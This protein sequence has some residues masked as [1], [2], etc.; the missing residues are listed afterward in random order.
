MYFLAADFTIYIV[1]C[2]KVQNLKLNF[3][4]V[5]KNV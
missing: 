2:V 4:T 3:T 1:L 5:I